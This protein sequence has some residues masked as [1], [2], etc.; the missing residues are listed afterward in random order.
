MKNILV[1]EYTFAIKI[2]ESGLNRYMY[3]FNFVNNTY[4][5]KIVDSWSEGNIQFRETII[6][7]S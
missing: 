5:Y 4:A 1:D 7:F 6:F 2:S 3:E